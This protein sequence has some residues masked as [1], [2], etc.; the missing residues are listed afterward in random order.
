[1]H[2]RSIEPRWLPLAA[3]IKELIWVGR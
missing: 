2:Q 3:G 1:L